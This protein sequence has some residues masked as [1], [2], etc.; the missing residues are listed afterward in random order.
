MWQ[1]TQDS[2]FLAVNGFARTTPAL[3][4]PMRL[5]A[6]YGVVL[7]AAVLLL[8]WWWARAHPDTETMAKALW[9][10]AGALLA[11]GLNQPLSNLVGEARPYTE[12]PHALVLVAHSQDYSFPSDHAVMAGAVA[13]GVLLTHRR[14]GALTVVAALLL[15][16]ARVYV[17]AH[18]PL[19][20][21][22]GLLFGAA[23]SLTGYLAV[24]RP[25]ASAVA[26]LTRTPV[27]P[28]VATS[29]AGVVR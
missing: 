7:F 6:E 12:F 21:I 29:R 27:R 17:G 9:A 28:L 13:V 26:G 8:S 19:D 5:Y 18:F 25:L 11:I 4:A 16:F 3:Q 20:V 15:A 10:P 2:W 24:R 23:V 14:L 1:H 22:V